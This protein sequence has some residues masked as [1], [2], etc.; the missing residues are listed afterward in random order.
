MTEKIEK[1]TERPLLETPKDRDQADTVIVGDVNPPKPLTWVVLTGLSWL[2]LAGLF[3]AIV[4]W[5]DWFEFGIMEHWRSVKQWL[6][7]VAFDWLPFRVRPWQIDYLVIGALMLRSIP[8]FIWTQPA[9][10]RAIQPDRLLKTDLALS[11]LL[12]AHPRKLVAAMFWPLVLLNTFA[13][14]LLDY[15]PDVPKEHVEIWKAR[16]RVLL[17]RMAWFGLSF[18]PILFVASNLL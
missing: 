17:L 6:I 14:Y 10:F 7:A 11:E 5:R 8:K 3:D 1:L 12:I 9:E 4:E 15:G 18:I 2:G 13:T 16:N